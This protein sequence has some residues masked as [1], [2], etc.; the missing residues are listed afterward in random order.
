MSNGNSLKLKSLSDTPELIDLGPLRDVRSAS[1]SPDSNCVAAGSWNEPDGV[2]V[3][4]IDNGQ[5]LAKFE[6]GNFCQ[7]KFSADGQFLFTSP[8]GGEIW[9]TSTWHRSCQLES[10]DNSATGIGFD[11]SPDSRWCV[12]TDGPGKLKLI[13]LASGKTLGVLT[14]PNLDRYFSVKVG[15]D[16]RMIFGTT[17]GRDGLIKCWNLVELQREMK[18]L[19]IEFAELC[20]ASSSDQPQFHSS[21]N[22]ESEE[23]ILKLESN[24]IY[25]EKVTQHVLKVS[26]EDR[27]QG[28]WKQN[29]ARLEQALEQLPDNALLNNNMAWAL[30]T[31]PSEYRDTERSIALA[32]KA[33]AIE[34]DLATWNTL[35]TALFQSG[36]YD[37]AIKALTTSLG[38]GSHS[39]AAFDYY[40]LA[41]C[42]AEIQK[43]DEAEQALKLGDD[44]LD[45]HRSSY[46][47]HELR[48]IEPFRQAAKRDV[49]RC[50]LR[51][52]TSD[53]PDSD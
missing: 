52:K 26:A 2:C 46:T 10:N 20:P 36:Q 42:Y 40:V 38:D 44:S 43:L 11:F 47:P 6:L 27:H 39:F 7:V 53:E 51:A 25:E 14:D 5:R 17:V 4:H 30:V 1:F 49:E 31:A 24:S 8:H 16:Q 15:S 3:W 41:S 28:H 12:V 48:E 37:K 35:G 34:D 13:E 21:S 18:Q 33:L 45:H 29:F 32:E 22:W 23:R 19:E 9:K 50:R